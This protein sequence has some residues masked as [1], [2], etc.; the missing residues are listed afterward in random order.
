[1]N[2]LH[3]ALEV[4]R[5]CLRPVCLGRPPL[6]RLGAVLDV[7]LVVDALGVENL[8]RERE[9]RREKGLGLLGLQGDVFAHGQQR[10]C[11]K[12]GTSAPAPAGTPRL[13]FRR[14]ASRRTRWG[15]P[16]GTQAQ[17]P[18]AH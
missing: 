4:Q 14:S 16:L 8:V 15:T 2:N 17:R 13:S 9:V 6:R 3:A 7:E 10:A 18:E 1:M 11:K 12:S 5:S